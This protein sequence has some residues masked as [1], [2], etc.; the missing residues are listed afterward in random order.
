M[1]TD[2]YL[3]ESARTASTLFRTDVVGLGTLTQALEDA[4]ALGKRVDQVKKGLFYGKPPKDAGL[5]GGDDGRLPESVPADLVHAALGIYTEAVEV[6]EALLRAMAG[7]TLDRT[8]LLE[9]VG[10][11]EWYLAMAYR[12]LGAHPDAVRQINIDKLRRRFP[13]K[14]TED[15][16]IDRDAAGERRLL[17]QGVLSLQ[18]GKPT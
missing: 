13:E 6:F 16:A 4:V 14:F 17:D 12:T 9:E 8:N 18:T 11:M 15:A 2:T 7:G 3:A 1:D 10:D 5:A